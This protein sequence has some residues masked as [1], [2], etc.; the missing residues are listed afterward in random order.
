MRALVLEVYLTPTKTKT[1]C[2]VCIVHVCL[3]VCVCMCVC[4]LCTS[5]IP[6]F[7]RVCLCVLVSALSDDQLH[8]R[9]LRAKKRREKAL[10]K[11]ERDKVH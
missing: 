6:V 4:V 10:E 2:C 8:R 7:T 11:S 5:Y 3:C 1:T 9:Q